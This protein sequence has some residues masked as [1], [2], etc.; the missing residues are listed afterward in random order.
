M[1][2]ITYTDTDNQQQSKLVNEEIKSLNLA[3]HHI[4][5]IDLSFISDFPDLKILYLQNNG[6]KSI[7]LDTISCC[8][9][10]KHINL[11]FNL[12]TSVDLN[13]ISNCKS[14]VFLDLGA[15]QL[16]LI[17]LEPLRDIRNLTGFRI[18]NN[19]MTEIDLS[20]LA[21]AKSL[22]MLDVSSNQ[23]TKIDLNPLLFCVN[24]KDLYLENNNLNEIDVTPLAMIGTKRRLLKD[25]SCRVVD[26]YHLIQQ[27][28]EMWN[29]QPNQCVEL[30]VW[31]LIMK[32]VDK[33]IDSIGEGECLFPI[34]RLILRALGISELG[35]YDGPLNDIIGDI[36][37]GMSM[38]AIKEVIYDRTIHLLTDQLR[39]GGLTLF[40]NIEKLKISKASKLVPLILECRR[41]ELENLRILKKSNSID[42]RHLWLTE[43]GYTILN[44][45]DI[46]EAMTSL[47]RYIE[48]EEAIRK[49]GGRVQQSLKGEICPDVSIGLQ[50]YIIQSI[51]SKMKDPNLAKRS[52]EIHTL[53]GPV[54]YTISAIQ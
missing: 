36:E 49:V 39:R 40:M 10:M 29:S 13:P 46:N 50:K 1:I 23:L 45:L 21:G 35:I 12:L 22:E 16:T 53:S 41:K 8:H 11:S 30:S 44:A 26:S 27:N 34:Q 5:D 38:S 42:L 43:Y 3:R 20:P 14:L 2:E 9:E 32:V 33:Y 7:E 18:D 28:E 6:L 19:N 31:N 4:R 54:E 25:I 48:I 17:D 51:N 52:L 15:N 47:S 37:L 24:L